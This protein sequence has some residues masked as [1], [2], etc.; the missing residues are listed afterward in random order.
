MLGRNCEALDPIRVEYYVYITW[1]AAEKSFSIYGQQ[2]DQVEAVMESLNHTF[3]QVIARSFAIDGMTRFFT[4]P[5]RAQRLQSKVLLLPSYPTKNDSFPAK[6][7]DARRSIQA[8]GPDFDEPEAAKLRKAAFTKNSRNEER[9][10]LTL[11]R[12]LERIRWFRGNLQMR[13]RLGSFVLSRYMKAPNDLYDLDIFKDMM[14][15][16]TVKAFVGRK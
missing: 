5:L 12:A 9:I 10:V 16:E 14:E 3:C 6:I 15:G 11:F 7:N 2:Q 4:K 8:Y 13:V 1:D